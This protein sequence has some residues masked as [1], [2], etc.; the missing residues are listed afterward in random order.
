MIFSK[1][2]RLSEEYYKWLN[3]VKEEKNTVVKDNA[4][5]VITF[6]DSIGKLKDEQIHRNIN[7]ANKRKS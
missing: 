7:S 6:L 5:A 3:E 1:R 4:L 2:Q